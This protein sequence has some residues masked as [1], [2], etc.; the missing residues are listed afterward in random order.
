MEL[1]DLGSKLSKL[2]NPFGNWKM[3]PLGKGF[4]EFSFV[5]PEDLRCVWTIGSWNLNPGLMRLFA[6]TP[7][8]NPLSL[9]QNNSQCWIRIFEL[10]QEYWRPKILF[11]IAGGLGTPISLDEATRKKD[12][13][14][15]ACVL[16][17]V[18][19]VNHQPLANFAGPEDEEE[20]YDG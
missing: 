2:W 17:D 12:L 8:F 1:N 7:D 18:D 19:L 3:V 16:V 14:H 9:K 13:G 6:W 15:F 11:S 4:F 5:S 20:F 10:P